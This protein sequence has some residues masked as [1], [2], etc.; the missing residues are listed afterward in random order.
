M[1]NASRGFSLVELVFVLLLISAMAVGLFRFNEGRR[2]ELML[3]A[4]VR[5]IVVDI[6]GTLRPFWEINGYSYGA[7]GA[8]GF[9]A[10]RAKTTLVKRGIPAAMP[11]RDPWEVVSRTSATVTIDFT[12]GGFRLG[13]RELVAAVASARE[14]D[15]LGNSNLRGV[16]STAVHSEGAEAALRVVYGR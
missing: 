6:P 4:A 14:S 3:S 12:C 9:D 13:C 16:T 11:W 15:P 1:K 10:D 8:P 7:L 2:A 5:T